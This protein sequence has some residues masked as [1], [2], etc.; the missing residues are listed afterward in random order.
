VRAGVGEG[1]P[2]AGGRRGADG[3]P[4]PVAAVRADGLEKG[5]RVLHRIPLRELVADC[6]DQ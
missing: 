2:V 6:G 1:G 3:E 5:G 4:D